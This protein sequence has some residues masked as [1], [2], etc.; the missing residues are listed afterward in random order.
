MDAARLQGLAGLA[1]VMATLMVAMPVKADSFETGAGVYGR[2]DHDLALSAAVGGAVHL[3]VG[4]ADRDGR[5]GA[6]ALGTAELRLHYLHTAGVVFGATYTPDADRTV[7][8]T[9][10]VELRPLFLISFFE[11]EFTG[12]SLLDLVRDNIGLEAGVRWDGRSPALL[13]GL[14]TEIPLVRDRDTGLFLRVGARLLFARSGWVGG[15]D[16]GTTVELGVAL[17]GQTA[18]SAGLL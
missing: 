2:F 10:A 11:N 5:S 4:G 3:G 18:V 7:A 15:N 16:A 1:F 13:L 12:D 17:Q 8:G 9:L 14:G 6:Q